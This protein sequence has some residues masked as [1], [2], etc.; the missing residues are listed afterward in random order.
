VVFVR[1]MALIIVSRSRMHAVS[2]TFFGLP[3]AIEVPIVVFTRGVLNR[4]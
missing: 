1:I 2:A 4:N 3:A